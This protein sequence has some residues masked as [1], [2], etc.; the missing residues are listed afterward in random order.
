MPQEN[1]QM[2]DRCMHRDIEKYSLLCWHV[3][4]RGAKRPDQMYCRSMSHRMNNNTCAKDLVAIDVYLN[5]HRCVHILK[6]AANPYG[7]KFPNSCASR[8]FRH[9]E[10][11]ITGCVIH[12][13]RGVHENVSKFRM[14]ENSWL[15]LSMQ[16][17][18]GGE[19]ACGIASSGS[20]RV[21][22]KAFL[23]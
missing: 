21:A 19:L 20:A 22:G 13:H 1:P 18:R 4:A 7:R 10:L 15:A 14:A 9:A 3:C 11:A 12:C 5:C 6:R 8:L 2:C 17:S 23:S 16:S